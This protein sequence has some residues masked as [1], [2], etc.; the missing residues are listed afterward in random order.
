MGQ[1]VVNSAQLT[2]SFGMA[3]SA[4]TV[5]PENKVL[6]AGQPAATIMDNVP[7]KNVMPFG[8]CVTL[9]NPQVAAAT[10]AALG[11][12][13]PQP[14][15]PVTTSPWTPGSPT[16][17]IAGNPALN[18]SCTLMCAWAGVISISSPGQQTVNIP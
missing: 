15:I 11:V 6:A 5:T 8:M 17:I 9:S 7:N 3:P 1:L 14:C 12:L 16:V 13:T 4:L 2:C 18:N 10:S